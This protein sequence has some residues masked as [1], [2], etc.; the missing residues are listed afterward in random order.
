LDQAQ[1]CSLSR[2]VGEGLGFFTPVERHRGRRHD[3]LLFKI[4]VRFPKSSNGEPVNIKKLETILPMFSHEF[5]S[6]NIHFDKLSVSTA[7]FPIRAEMLSVKSASLKTGIN[8][9]VGNYTVTDSLEI[10]TANAP[11]S[12]HVVM[13]NANKGVPTRLFV[14]TANAP[15]YANVSLVAEGESG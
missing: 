4:V 11:V 15:L 3:E 8:F 10:L 7:H 13:K 9:I 12:V 14:G 6:A 5:P 1:V 2:A